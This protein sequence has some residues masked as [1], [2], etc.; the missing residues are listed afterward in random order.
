MVAKLWNYNY[1]KLPQNVEIKQMKT[2]HKS[3]TKSSTLEYL[4]VVSYLASSAHSLV[5]QLY[6]ALADPAQKDI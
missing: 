1:S 4:T 2:F 6:T 5:R 3:E